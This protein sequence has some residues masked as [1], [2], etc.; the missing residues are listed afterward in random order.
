MSRWPYRWNEGTLITRRQRR[1]RGWKHWNTCPCV[2]HVACRAENAAEKAAQEQREAREARR[3]LMV[4]TR[5]ARVDPTMRAPIVAA[6]IAV[7]VA[8]LA[9]IGEEMTDLGGL[10]PHRLLTPNDLAQVQAPSVGFDWCAHDRSQRE[11]GER[12]VWIG[13]D[14][15]LAVRQMARD[16]ALEHG[17]E[18]VLWARRV[19]EVR[20]RSIDPGHGK[21]AA[22]LLRGVYL[23]H[24]GLTRTL[25]ALSREHIVLRRGRAA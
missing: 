5:P 16:D 24:L 14:D 22:A 6:M 17:D 15:V 3:P 1:C 20:A 25:R 13:R 9:A 23:A 8:E 12:V 21:R 4:R 10:V 11:R 7:V 2:N 19:T 18:H